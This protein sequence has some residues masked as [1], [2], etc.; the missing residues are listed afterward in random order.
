MT[1]KKKIYLVVSLFLT[2]IPVYWMNRSE[3]PVTAG[4]I[5]SD[6]LVPLQVGDPSLRLDL[7]E[8]ARS[9]DY[10]GD[11]RN[12]FGLA[13][14]PPSPKEIAKIAEAKKFRNIG[15]QP[16]PPPPPVTVPATFFGYALDPQS[17]KRRA[18]FTNGE[19]VF[20]VEEGGMLLNHFRLVK[21]GNNSADLEET[22]SGRH[23]TVPLTEPAASPAG[24]AGANPTAGAAARI[25][26][27]RPGVPP[28][29]ESE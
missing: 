20:I 28:P 17:G 15:P 9:R 7:L 25:G 1:D 18:F 27:P 2:A 23:A 4:A 11:H 5:A 6:R 21:I 14:P 12:I 26:A 3:G 24:P 29:T 16:P 19:D 10:S 8:H 22:A 13:P